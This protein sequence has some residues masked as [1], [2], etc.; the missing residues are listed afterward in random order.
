MKK[1]I[2]W[3]FKICISVPV[4]EKVGSST[5]FVRWL[6][7]FMFQFI[8]FEFSIGVWLIIFIAALILLTFMLKWNNNVSKGQVMLEKRIICLVGIIFSGLR[9]F[10]MIM[11]DRRIKKKK[12][13]NNNKNKELHAVEEISVSSS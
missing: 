8:L 10:F 13:N 1:K 5:L 12:Y 11:Y 9:Y 6:F 3:N 7:H 4:I 2:L